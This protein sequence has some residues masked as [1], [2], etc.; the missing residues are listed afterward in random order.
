LLCKSLS[1]IGSD[2][3][4]LSEESLR[5]A[6]DMEGGKE[7]FIRWRVSAMELHVVKIDFRPSARRCCR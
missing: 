2:D 1:F 7:R 3:E 6:S 5:G 4:L